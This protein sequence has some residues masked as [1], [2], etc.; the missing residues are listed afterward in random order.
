MAQALILIP[1]AIAGLVRD[2]SVARGCVSPLVDIGDDDPLPPGAAHAVGMFR[3]RVRRE[4]LQHW[5]PELPRLRW[6]HTASAGVDHFYFPALAERGIILTTGRGAHSESVAEHAVALL[7]ALAKNLAAHVIAQ[8]ER[9]WHHVDGEDLAGKTLGVLGLGSIGRAVAGRA[10]A[11]GMHVVGIRRSG[12]PVPEA[13]TVWGPHGLPRLLRESHAVVLAA[14]LTVQTRHVINEGALRA[15]RPS[16][17]LVNVARGE[18]IDEEALR[19]ALR[20]RWIAGA[21]LDA[22]REEPLLP[23]NPLYDTPH[24]LIT[25]HVSALTPDLD[26]RMA[27]LFAENLRRFESHDSL[28][29]VYSVDEEY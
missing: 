20:E 16:A 15:M 3:Y 28:L 21:A 22:F 9:R 19:R 26:L 24:L 6:M 18:L 11:L 7:L 23:A 8:Q 17:W 13:D 5:L 25:S 12:Q 4:R 27:A 10:R 2:A 14:P 29:N 1:R